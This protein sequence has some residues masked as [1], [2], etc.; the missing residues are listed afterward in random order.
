MIGAT[1]HPALFRLLY[2]EPP[3]ASEGTIIMNQAKAILPVPEV[4]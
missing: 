3:S 4:M 1:I 2:L